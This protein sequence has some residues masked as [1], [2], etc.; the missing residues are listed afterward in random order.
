MTEIIKNL[1]TKNIAKIFF[2]TVT[3]VLFSCSEEDTT[4]EIIIEPTPIAAF[5]ENATVEDWK[6]IEFT[7]RSTNAT[8]YAW[9]FG[10]GNTA[11]VAEPTN[12]YPDAGTYTVTL[13]VNGDSDN[14]DTVEKTVV[15]FNPAA[16]IVDFTA[17]EDINDW[18]TFN[19][20]NHTTKATS[21]VWDFGDG[22]TSTQP[23][24]SHQYSGEE[25][26]MEYT[27]RLTAT[28]DATGD[29]AYT[30]KIISVINPDPIADPTFKVEVFNVTFNE[31]TNN[32]SDNADGWD[33]TPNSTVVDND[34]NTVTSPYTWKNS[35]LDSWLTSKYIDDSEQPSSTGDGNKFEATD[36]GRGV[37]LNEPGRRIYQEVTVEK[38]VIYTLTIDS[39]S[40]VE[41]L[42]SEVYILNNTAMI[43]EDGLD[44]N[45]A[46]DADVDELFVI[47]ND[48]N[49][50]KSSSTSDTFT[51]NTFTFKPSTDKIVIYVRCPGAVD[52]DTE[53]FYDNIDIIT[54]GF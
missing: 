51:T 45:G 49:S 46:D 54:P 11:D 47:T 8:T 7:D 9:D 40:E 38:N 30:E 12:E 35:E 50:S 2:L 31:F 19:F 22:G 41:G 5:T 44:L 34:G 32:T 26:V 15:V 53:V 52:S 27:V 23:E 43:S 36:G 29:S 10:D 13:T 21:Y 20:S 14:S 17:T 37:K 1:S 33:M 39:R 25:D 48:F 6:I 3:A 24:P 42:N 28:N 18:K 16:P 4:E